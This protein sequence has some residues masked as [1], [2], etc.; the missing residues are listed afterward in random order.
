MN[1]Y[2]CGLL[3]SDDALEIALITKT[4]KHT[5]KWQA[6]MLNGIGGKVKPN[7]NEQ[8]AM[9]REFFEEAGV[10]TN[11]LSWLPFLTLTGKNVGGED[12]KVWFYKMFDSSVL[13]NMKTMTDE[14]VDKYN[15]S[16]VRAEHEAGRVKMIS[17]LEWI[18]PLALDEDDIR[19]TAIY[20]LK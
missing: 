4:D 11:P 2:V 13:D 20:N 6:G 10:K 19:V 14:K 17:N 12:F 1:I 7:E 18:I 8:D 15:L 5:L 9:A 3:F 16:F